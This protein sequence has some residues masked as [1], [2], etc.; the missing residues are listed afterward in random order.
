MPNEREQHRLALRS[1][2]T[3]GLDDVVV[4]DVSMFR[5]ERLDEVTLW[6]ACY[7]P[8]TGVEGDRVTFEVSARDGR[9]DFEVVER[10]TGS[11]SAEPH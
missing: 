8:G 10:P 11:V 9:L 7:L 5:A 2:T 6:L 3:G 4:E 1:L